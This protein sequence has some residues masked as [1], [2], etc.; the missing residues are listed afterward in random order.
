MS[1]VRNPEAGARSVVSGYQ[2]EEKFDF[3]SL[4]VYQRSLEYVDFVY[5]LTRGFPKTEAFALADQFRRAV[6]SVSLNIAEGSGG[7]K[8]EFNRY[9][10]IARRSVRECVAITEISHRQKFINGKIR[11][12]SRGFCTELS[13]MLNGLMK[14]LR[15]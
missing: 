1:F 9:L 11:E 4:R 6:V 8:I 7:T 13:K 14:S 5:D 15:T 12:Q 3:E 2:A 10:K